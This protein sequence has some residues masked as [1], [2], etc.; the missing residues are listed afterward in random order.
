MTEARD[1]L[2]SLCARFGVATEYDD[3]WGARHAVSDANLVALLAQFD[4]DAST[5]ERI[6]QAAHEARLAAD[7][8]ALPPVVTCETGVQPWSVVLTLP[9]TMLHLQWTITEENGA[10]HDGRTAVAA[11]AGSEFTE[12]DGQRLR[13][14][15]LTLGLE[16]PLGYHTLRIND[17]PGSCL[18]IAAPRRCYRP[19]AL[20]NG[21]RV[22]GPAVQLYGVRSE[23]NWGV[24]DFGDL[25]CLIEQWADRGAGIIGVNPLHALFSHNP[26]HASPYSPSS[27]LRFNALYLDVE[28]IDDFR[29]CEEAQRQVRSAQF[30]ARLAGLRDEPLVNYPGVAAAKF[31]ILE[32]LYAHFSR[33]QLKPDRAR[34]RAFHAFQQQ[35]GALLRRHA[36]FE[37]LQAHF[38]ATD[39]SIWGWPVWPQ[40]YRDPESSAVERFVAEHLDRIEFH[41]YL[42]WQAEHQLAQLSQR[43]RARGLAVGLYFD[44]SVSVDRAGSDT[45]THADT[46]ALG[47]SI[48]CPPD[49]FNLNGQDW[50][51]PPLRPDRLRASH[52][53]LFRATLSQSMHGAGALRIDHVMGLM[54]LFWIPPG[55]TAADGAYVHYALDEMLAI[56]ALESQRHRCMVIGEDLGTVAG[57]MRAALARFEVLSYRLLYFE[58]GA[59]G[60]FRSSADYPR[61]ALVAVSTHDLATLAGWW[62]GQDLRLRQALGL[63]P[64]QA[65][66]EQQLLDR[67]QD[68]V[69]ILLILQQ[70]GLLPAGMEIEPGGAPELTP[71]LAEAI[72]AFMAMTPSRV[73]MVQLEDALGVTEQANLPG[74]TAEHPNW[75]CK[76][77]E[78]LETMALNERVNSLASRLAALRPHPELH[79]SAAPATQPRV[80]RA[81]Y[82]LQFNKDFTFDDAVRML[83]YLARLCVSHVYCSPILRARPGSM[84]GYDIVA[85][86]EINPELGGRDGFERFSAALRAHGMGQI[87]DMVPNHMG[88]LGADNAWW[89]DVLENGP[90]SIYAQYFDIDWQPVN[91]DLAAKVLV[92]VL[93]DH[94]GHILESGQLVVSF[95]PALGTFVV[96]Y[97]AHRFPIDPGTYPVLLKLAEPHIADAD[98][99]ADL[100]SLIAAFSYLPARSALDARAM[101]ERARDKEMHKTRLA[102][103]AAQHADVLQAIEAVIGQ[104][105]AQGAH[106]ALHELLEAQAYRLAYWRVAADEINYRRFFDINELAALRME[107]EQVFEATQGF[108]LELAAVGMVDGLR[109][110][111]P[112]GLYDPAQY[113]RRLQEGY[114]SR[115]NIT[116]PE[117][118]AQ[119]RPARPLYVVVEKIAAL[120]EQ[121]PESWHVHGST[122]YR[123]GALVNGVL[124]DA[125]AG[126][127]FDRIWRAFTHEGSSFAELAYLGKRA[128]M[129]SALASELTVL[130]AEL[131]RIARA[132]RRT[133]DYT[134]NTLRN[135]LAEVCACLPVYRTYIVDQPSAQDIRYVEWAVAHARRR[136]R[137]AESS[138]FDFVRQSLLGQAIENATSEGRAQVR[139]FAMRFQQFSAPVAAKGVED[140]AFYCYSRLASLNEVGGDPDQFGV[141]VK[142][143]HKLSA[144]RAADWPYTLLATSTHDN[145]RSEDVRNRIDVLSEIPAAW[146]LTLRRWSAMNRSHHAV[147]DD[148]IAPSRADEYLLYQTLLGTLPAEGL[149]ALSRGP[150]RER[151]ERYMIKAAREAKARTSWINPNNDYENALTGFVRALLTDAHA[152]RFLDDLQAQAQTTT[153]FG[154]LNS[155]SMALV[156]FTSPGVPDLYQGNELMDLSLVDPDNRHPVDYSLRARWLAEMAQLLGR[157]DIA[158]G[159]AG[160][161]RAPH[162]GKAKLWLTWRLLALRQAFALLFR[163]GAYAGLQIGGAQAAHVLAF[164]R[165]HEGVRVLTISGRLF[166]RLL[167]GRTGALPLGEGVWL[168]TYV[169]VPDLSDGTRLENVLTGQTQLV[170]N[171]RISMAQTFAGFPAAALLVRAG[172]AP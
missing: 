58:R 41:E 119:G 164:E 46:Y 31:E 16:L 77:P 29:H 153:W 140:T 24:G 6:A 7:S 82:R 110:D 25:A 74:T 72:H 115:A 88:V 149:G 32:K 79:P 167:G 159:V 73:M 135:A 59:G 91:P 9:D 17:L 113:F 8:H 116:L 124:V 103:M 162:D 138:I 95:E 108:T 53:R 51:L 144:E 66:H 37:A 133:R 121:V 105:N 21:G 69:R 57:E 76:L 39:S 151:I 129:R 107:N 99:R 12:I 122:G 47:S 83:P 125:S 126:A 54:R 38:Y 128:I 166:A 100:S 141:P 34:A 48:G 158:Q 118:D 28:A 55:K 62:H 86:D 152:N 30:Q 114:A 22:W 56:M 33:Y 50:G 20:E 11:L 102:G 61:E 36:S 93:G 84:H 142:T 154:A 139:R 147:V 14:C 170:E 52:Y 44:L 172:A 40:A 70:S 165:R 150:Y 85:H 67:A 168:D 120:H 4:V 60:E 65:S 18:V 148:A 45:W 145:K 75:R 130:A 5:P 94:Y 68:R 2:E 131:L 27:R 64:D 97:H 92:P 26:A 109:I 155:L 161:A 10:K 143:F 71:P 146:R 136:S 134:F 87:L 111:H 90:A 89:T 160:F 49:E 3:I 163:D 15:T 117:L 112:D 101:G 98:A 81:T 96:N 43:V 127:R 169:A 123:F 23:R 137:A 132:D 35:G 1:A 42:Q 13:T 80:P 171:S 78:N 104:L 19:P 156:K 157:G 63:F 106:D